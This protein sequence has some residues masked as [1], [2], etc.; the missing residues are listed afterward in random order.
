MDTLELQLEPSIGSLDRLRAFLESQLAS[1]IP[2]SRHI[3]EILVAATELFVNAC[4]HGQIDP[5]GTIRIQTRHVDG[6]FEVT[7]EYVGNRFDPPAADLPESTDLPESGLGLFIVR[8]LS[9]SVRF[10][11]SATPRGVQRV[12][13]RKET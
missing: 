9:D 2:P 4:E 12:V 6:D 5:G 10:D 1:R 13:F 11:P 8:H 7:M 3:P